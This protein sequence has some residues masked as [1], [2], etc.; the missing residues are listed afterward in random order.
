MKSSHFYCASKKSKPAL[1]NGST[2]WSISTLSTSFTSTS[3][4]TFIPSPSPSSLPLVISPSVSQT[5]SNTPHLLRSSASYTPY[6]PRASPSSTP[7]T[8]PLSS[9]SSVVSPFRPA[10]LPNPSMQQ[11]SPYPLQQ[12]SLE[13]M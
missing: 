2:P 6:P 7:S 1:V 3:E 10:L 5:N 12:P 13:S 9:S 4:P 8:S 11:E